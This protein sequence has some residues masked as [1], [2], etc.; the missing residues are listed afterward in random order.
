M[1]L[2]IRDRER[3]RDA[4]LDIA[5]VW[6]RPPAEDSSNNERSLAMIDMTTRVSFQFHWFRK[7]TAFS[8]FLPWSGHSDHPRI[9]TKWSGP[10][11]VRLSGLHCTYVR[12]P[13]NVKT[14]GNRLGSAGI[15][16]NLIQDG[17][18]NTQDFLQGLSLTSCFG[19][20]L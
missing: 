6:D 2:Q 15:L 18:G 14:R 7:L 20:S 11:V 5:V 9:R 4:T 19:C 12:K 8:V 13:E 3:R 1:F 17:D 16:R 10:D